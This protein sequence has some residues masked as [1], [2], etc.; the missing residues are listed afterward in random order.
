[1]EMLS[2]LQYAW[3]MTTLSQERLQLHSVVSRTVGA[4]LDTQPRACRH[5]PALHTFVR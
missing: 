1:M 4:L 5:M 3:R 2:Q